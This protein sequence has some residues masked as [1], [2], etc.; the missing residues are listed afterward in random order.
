[1]F[2]TFARAKHKA[3]RKLYREADQGPT[4]PPPP[5]KSSWREL[6]LDRAACESLWPQPEPR[7]IPAATHI[8]EPL[9]PPK[10][11]SEPSIHEAMGAQSPDAA[12][13]ASIPLCAG[14]PKRADTAPPFPAALCGTHGAMTENPIGLVPL[15]IVHN[16]DRRGEL[17]ELIDAQWQSGRLALW[18][19][20]KDTSFP[21]EKI[22]QYKGLELLWMA[23]PAR[24][25][26]YC[27]CRS[28]SLCDRKGRILSAHLG[29]NSHTRRRFGSSAK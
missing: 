24:E 10:A 29:R 23:G 19:R 4:K 28:T 3:L 8:E 13:G 1:M 6:L 7:P 20:R 5:R 26:Y 27:T 14:Q 9:A 22:N 12:P 16:D 21:V 17:M 11:L 2:D 15:G 25:D 18:G